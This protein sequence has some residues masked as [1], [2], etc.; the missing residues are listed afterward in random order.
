MFTIGVRGSLTSLPRRVINSKSS[1][2]MNDLVV[3]EKEDEEK[4]KNKIENE[5][6]EIEGE[7]VLHVKCNTKKG[8]NSVLVHLSKGVFEF[9][10]LTV[11]MWKC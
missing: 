9:D 1:T 10:G 2:K 3:S 7:R 4:E 11:H 8:L 5:E 6:D